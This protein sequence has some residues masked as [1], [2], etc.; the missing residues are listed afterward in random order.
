MTTAPSGEQV[1][2]RA[3]EHQATVVQVGG[4]LRAYEHAGRPVLDG[5]AES[6]MASSA[7]GQLLIPWPNRLHGGQYTW[8]GTTHTVPM[9]E[10]DQQNALHGLTRWHLWTPSDRSE[11]AVTMTL[12]LPPTPP[13]PFSLDLAARYELAED[14]LTVTMSATNVGNTDAP[15]GCGAHPYV[16][17]GTP[18]VDEA[19]LHLPAHTW[20][21]TGVAQVPQGR[22]SVAGTPYDFRTARRL[23]PLRIDYAFTDLD[24]DK[25]GLATLTLSHR[26]RSVRLW[27]D[28]AFGYLEVFTADTVSPERR[29]RGL[30]VEPMTCPPNAFR[31]GEDVVRLRPGETS[32]GRWGIRPL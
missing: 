9:D 16:T 10:P 11:T 28:E 3:G 23:G 13:Y 15:Y 24:R 19:T 18:T 6:A 27:V 29:R 21:P 12:L 26:D 31:S 22:E 32:R 1:V 7:R 20:L 14:G 25:E 8:D 5:Y 17:V 4:G 2:L 30:G